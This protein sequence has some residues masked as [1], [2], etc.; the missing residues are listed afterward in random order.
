MKKKLR[1][2]FTRFSTD[3][4]G[5]TA[6]EYALIAGLVTIAIIASLNLFS[7]ATTNLFNLV[8]NTLQNSQAGN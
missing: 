8:S 7:G 2:I 5:A 4:S 1:I 3:Q 6:I